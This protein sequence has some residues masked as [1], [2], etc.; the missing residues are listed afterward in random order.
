MNYKRGTNSPAIIPTIG[1][2][3]LENGTNPVPLYEVET[4]VCKFC[5]A[6]VSDKDPFASIEDARTPM[7]K[8]LDWHKY[9]HNTFQTK[10]TGE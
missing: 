8:H 2:R 10:G 1:L 4:S 3:L 9:L 5:W 6:L 7:E